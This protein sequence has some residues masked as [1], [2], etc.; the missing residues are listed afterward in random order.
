MQPGSGRTGWVER[1]LTAAA[2]LL[3]G[4]LVAMGG[5]SA[6]GEILDFARERQIAI[7]ENFVQRLE[8][9]PMTPEQARKVQGMV[10]QYGKAYLEALASFE[11][12]P[13]GDLQVLGKIISAVPEETQVLDF[14]YSGRDLTVR[15]LQPRWELAEQMAET[16]RRGDTFQE[17][18]CSGYQTADGQ[19]AADLTLQAFDYETPLEEGFHWGEG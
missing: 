13:R 3:A 15:T 4:V 7:V 2:F 10:I 9:G 19:W 17:V 11:F 14:T 1:L 5:V 18:I 8:T 16:L 6:A 12:V